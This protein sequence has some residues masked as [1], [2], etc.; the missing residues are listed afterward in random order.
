[1]DKSKVYN[2]LKEEQAGGSSG[3]SDSVAIHAQTSSS[4]VSEA[5]DGRS[6]HW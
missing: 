4:G 5:A 1:M 3:S 6:T 2:K